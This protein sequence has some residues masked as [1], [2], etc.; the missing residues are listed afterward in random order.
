M[1]EGR[2]EGREGGRGGGGGKGRHPTHTRAPPH[3]N[4][5]DSHTAHPVACGYLV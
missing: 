3:S 2:G 4:T 5:A 1:E